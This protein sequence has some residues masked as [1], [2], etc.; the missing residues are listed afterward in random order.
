MNIA[1]MTV[2]IGLLAI[3]ACSIRGAEEAVMVPP[4]RASDQSDFYLLESPWAR[5][6]S[7]DY[8][9]HEYRQI[10]KRRSGVESASRPKNMLGL[11]L[12]GGGIRS[13]AFQ[14]GFLSGLANTGTPEG[15][16]L[17]H[18]DLISSVSGGSWANGAY[19]AWHEDD[20]TL[21]VCLD[22]AAEGGTESNDERCRDPER[23]LR[24]YQGVLVLPVDDG[25]LKQR[26]EK[27]EE[28]I[29][30]YYLGEGNRNI[31]FTELQEDDFRLLEKPYPIFNSTHDAVS[32]TAN[33][34]NLHFETTPHYLG[35]VI[36]YRSNGIDRFI[37][38]DNASG[39]LRQECR[40]G[41]T[42]FFTRHDSKR[43][44]WENRKWQRWW[45]FWRK[46]NDRP[47]STLSLTM[48]HSS[49]VVGKDKQIAL[50]YNFHLR[51]EGEKIDSL[52]KKYQ[53]VDG[54]KSDNSGLLPLIERKV[55]FII[56]THL[57]KERAA[58]EDLRLLSR[59]ARN[60]YGCEVEIPGDSNPRLVTISTYTCAGKQRLIMHVKPTR[61]NISEFME[62][63]QGGSLCRDSRK[64]V[65]LYRKLIKLEEPKNPYDQFP[66]TPTFQ[67]DY[68]DELIRAYYLLGRY[69]ASTIVSDQLGHWMSKTGR[70]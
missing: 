25:G 2:A 8:F 3:A 22:L 7:D 69:A 56:A 45:K 58:F 38:C 16:R 70:S 26:K 32:E 46:D 28:D 47:G 9:R 50:A 1:P 34:E 52:R 19:W 42:G 18:V 30:T 20:E 10:N 48:A 15:T 68:P 41:K 65:E 4:E 29:N 40:K 63:L 51:K 36:D 60:I 57:G 62:A 67:F 43:Y 55:D 54:G 24:S 37:D 44:K 66:A 49:G 59:Q 33:V 39:D 6:L 14:L 11:A 35:T 31:D 23:M 13:A 27:W 17:S 53:L 21:F 5:F 64:C 12:S 61:R